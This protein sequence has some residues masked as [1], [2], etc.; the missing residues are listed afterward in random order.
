MAEQIQHRGLKAAYQVAQLHLDL[1]STSQLLVED[2]LSVMDKNRKV[3]PK[4]KATRVH[5]YPPCQ[6]KNLRFTI[7]TLGNIPGETTFSLFLDSVH[8]LDI[9]LFT[10]ELGHH[11]E[12][13]KIRLFHKVLV[14]ILC[15]T[16]ENCFH[17]YRWLL[18]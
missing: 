15:R 7:Y 11:K 12:V 8:K 10:S 4:I 13:I 17:L 2:C 3:K 6:I 14:W 9:S 5:C 1:W 16:W 18:V